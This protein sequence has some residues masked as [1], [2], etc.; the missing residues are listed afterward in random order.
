MLRYL[1]SRKTAIILPAVILLLSLPVMYAGSARVRY[2]AWCGINGAMFLMSLSLLT[3]TLARL[4]SCMVSLKKG[5]W[6]GCGIKENIEV[7]LEAGDVVRI[8]KDKLRGKG[9]RVVVHN[10]RLTAVKNFSGQMGSMAFHLGIVVVLAGFLVNFAWGFR[11]TVFIPE[12]VMVRVP[13]DLQF[14]EKGIFYKPGNTFVAALDRFSYGDADADGKNSIRPYSDIYFSDGSHESMQ[15]LRINYP[16]YY[17]GTFWE[18]MDS[19]YSLFL[20]IATPEGTVVKDYVNIDSQGLKSWNDTVP[21]A[22]DMLLSIRFYPD[23][24]TGKQGARS[25]SIFPKNP[26]VDLTLFKKGKKIGQAFI[27]LGR[28]AVIGDTRIQFP[29]YRYWQVFDVRSDPGRYLIL[30]G[31]VALLLGL[32]WRVW[33]ITRVVVL[34]VKPCD[35]RSC[36]VD[37]GTWASSGRSFWRD[38]FRKI[39]E[40]LGEQQ[41]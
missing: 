29:A 7:P 27:P 26:V 22:Q 9:Y 21:L 10:D 14:K 15:R 11:A 18:Y 40:K 34:S 25:R 33:A 36:T 2:W 32:L 30:S 16:V 38:E 19:G 6:P 5:A 31:F 4:R 37:W 1:K 39:L 24:V 35:A 23:F 28:D 20:D 12:K 17:K 3:C 8:M 41:A 13:D